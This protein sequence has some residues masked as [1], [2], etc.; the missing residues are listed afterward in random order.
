MY[1]VGKEH[2]PYERCVLEDVSRELSGIGD[3]VEN[4]PFSGGGSVYAV[5]YRRPADS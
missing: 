3:V 5:A 2:P 4:G 1:A